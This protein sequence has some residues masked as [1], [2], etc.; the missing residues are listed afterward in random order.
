MI[1]LTPIF[2]FLWVC[3]LVFQ[4]IGE[5]VTS[6]WGCHTYF[7]PESRIFMG[8]RRGISTIMPLLFPSGSKKLSIGTFIWSIFCFCNSNGSFK[9]WPKVLEIYCLCQ[10]IC[11]PQQV[12]K[13]KIS[14][15]HFNFLVKTTYFQLL[16][17]Y[18][19]T[20]PKEPANRSKSDQNIIFLFEKI[21]YFRPTCAGWP[22]I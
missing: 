16:L 4:W 12:W 11:K 1:R 10:L 18:Q 17:K 9:I 3:H 5:D 13:N 8:S 7:S 6:S 20:Q 21:I 14:R 22:C 15:N 2:W 19:M